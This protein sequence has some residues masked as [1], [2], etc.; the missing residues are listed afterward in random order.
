MFVVDGI[1]G[2]IGLSVVFVSVVGCGVV[3]DDELGS[4]RSAVE[5]EK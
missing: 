2:L 3:V 5:A 1:V 4:G